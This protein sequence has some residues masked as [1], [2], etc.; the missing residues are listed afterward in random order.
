MANSISLQRFSCC[1]QGEAEVSDGAPCV[2]KTAAARREKSVSFCF[3]GFVFA[4][5]PPGFQRAAH[6]QPSVMSQSAL[7]PPW[8]EWQRPL[9]RCWPRPLTHVAVVSLKGKRRLRLW[10]GGCKQRANGDKNERT[11]QEVMFLSRSLSLER[12][13]KKYQLLLDPTE[14]LSNKI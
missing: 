5:I 12:R 8:V 1:H 6:V 3:W 4:F 7:T 10:Q 13:G 9:I 14:T 11:E 2:G